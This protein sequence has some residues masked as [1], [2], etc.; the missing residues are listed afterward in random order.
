L[1]QFKRAAT[2]R[3]E[4]LVETQTSLFG[5]FVDVALFI[6]GALMVAAGIVEEGAG[7]AV[8]VLVGAGLMVMGAVL[9]RLSGTIKIS[10]GLV[11]MTVVQQLEATRQLAEQQIPDQTEEAVGLA[12]QKLVE[13]GQ[14]SDLLAKAQAPPP[15]PPPKSFS[16]SK[17]W[18]AIAV[19]PVIALLIGV[20]AVTLPQAS[21]P[22]SRV[23]GDASDS[24]PVIFL[25]SVG[26][27]VVAVGGAA[28]AFQRR[29]GSRVKLHLGDDELRM[30]SQSGEPP[31][32]F[33]RQI[34]DE[35]VSKS[36]P[37]Q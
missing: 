17:L 29:R 1:V 27:V 37:E 5:R 3:L 25:V 32:F 21:D 20:L 19:A 9:P 4:K 8:L 22:P 28:I 35:I 33:A 34:V 13:S 11:E 12:F 14:L 36:Q 7:Q 30:A 2:G 10:P 6:V 18:R 15:P 26:V 24:S 31:W 23:N 16:R